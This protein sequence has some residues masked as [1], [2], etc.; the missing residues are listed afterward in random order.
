[1]RGCR[2][3]YFRLLL[4]LYFL[5]LKNNTLVQKNLAEIKHLFQEKPDKDRQK[6][7]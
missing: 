5:L 7:R 3:D 4:L 1:M 6:E 2:K